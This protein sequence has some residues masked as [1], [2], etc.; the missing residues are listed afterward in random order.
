MRVDGASVE[1]LVEVSERPLVSVFMPDRLELIK[2]APALRRAHLDQFVA[3]L[4]PARV[5][6]RRG[7]VQTL[8]QR[9]ALIARIRAGGARRASL[10]SWD[11]Q[12]AARGIELMNDRREAIDAVGASFGRIAADLGLD[13]GPELAYR[14][15]SKAATAPELQAELEASVESD[16]ER[17]FT[18]HGPHRDDVSTRRAGRELRAYGSQGQQ[19]LALLAL[20]LAEREALAAHRQTPPVMLLDDVMSELDRHRRR[21]LVELLRASGGQ[22]VI[23]ATDLEQIPSADVDGVAR[24]SV[25]DGQV[26]AEAVTA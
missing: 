18:V 24:L 22:S 2:G 6:A 23:T 8:A 12:L 4:R 19:R 10:T 21:A 13:G 14:P 5:A 26:L 17:G 7:Y 25:S 15:R 16:L 9:N 1:R 3:A 11:A 20:L